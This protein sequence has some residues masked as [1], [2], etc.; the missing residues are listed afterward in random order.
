[1][2]PGFFIHPSVILWLSVLYYLTP[3]VV[4]PFLLASII[5]E[6]GHY[7]V[8]CKLK[9]APISLTVTFSGAVMETPP[10]GYKEELFAALGGPVASFL[11]GLF[12]PFFPAF[13]LYGI[14]LGL[15]NLIPIPGL[16]G[17]KILKNSLSI[18]LGPEKS[19]TL[20]AITAVFAALLL[21]LG[22]ITLSRQ[23]EMGW[24]IVALTAIFLLR[25]LHN[26]LP[27]G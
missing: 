12:I 13:G 5:H 4:F 14:I 9:K 16:D 26:A 20:C 10:L 24:W 23:Q 19:D 21:F 6:I 2:I 17:D 1:M 25:S 15:V 27:L 18:T 3:E 22:S 7:I 11:C 8:L